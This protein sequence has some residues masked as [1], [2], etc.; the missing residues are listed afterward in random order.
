MATTKRGNKGY[1]VNGHVGMARRPWFAL[2]PSILDYACFVSGVATAATDPIGHTHSHSGHERDARATPGFL[3]R[4]TLSNIRIL[5]SRISPSNPTLGT[6]PPPNH[7]RIGVAENLKS[8]LVNPLDIGFFDRIA[9]T[10]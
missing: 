10:L 3:K 1:G 8:R 7:H 6:T 9:V 4:P 5:L 2:S